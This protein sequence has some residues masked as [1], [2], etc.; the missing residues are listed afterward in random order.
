MRPDTAVISAA[1][2]LVYF[3]ARCDDI[4][5]FFVNKPG[6]HAQVELEPLPKSGRCPERTGLNLV[7]NVIQCANGGKVRQFGLTDYQKR[8]LRLRSPLI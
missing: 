1:G 8:A 3:V 5:F 6:A 4:D 2:A 7:P